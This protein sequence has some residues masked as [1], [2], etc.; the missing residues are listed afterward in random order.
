[1]TA[2]RTSAASSPGSQGQDRKQAV[3]VEFMRVLGPGARPSGVRQAGS[4]AIA[5]ELV[6]DRPQCRPR[7]SMLMPSWQAFNE[8]CRSRA[9]GERCWQLAAGNDSFSWPAARWLG[10]CLRGAA[11]FFSPRRWI[12]L[13]AAR[14]AVIQAPPILFSS[15]CLL[16]S[17]PVSS[18]RTIQM[19]FRALFAA[20][21][22]F[23][24]LLIAPPAWADEPAQDPAA[25]AAVPEPGRP[26]EKVGWLRPNNTHRSVDAPY[27]IVDNSGRVRCFVP[28]RRR[29]QSGRLLAP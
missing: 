22:M 24:G 15:A 2:A 20:A 26:A 19:P 10:Q 13:D 4:S 17:S 1:M 6:Q 27:A 8:R 25:D 12:G 29:G 18:R 23:C 3:S 16:V 14:R 9:A 11:P 5:E 28:P 21:L 7:S